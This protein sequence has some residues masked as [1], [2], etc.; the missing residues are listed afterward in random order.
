MLR[1]I[2]IEKLFGLYNYD[3][4][5][6]GHGETP[7]FLTGPNGYGKSTIL[8]IIDYIYREDFDSLREV[9]FEKLQLYF[10]N[11]GAEGPIR[12]RLTVVRL[13]RDRGTYLL[14]F[15]VTDWDTAIDERGTVFHYPGGMMMSLAFLMSEDALYYIHDQRLTRTERV[16]NQ[17]I[18]EPT[19]KGNAEEFSNWLSELSAK[20]QQELSMMNLQFSDSIS[21]DDYQSRMAAVESSFLPLYRY[22][23]IPQHDC[24]AYQKENSM[25]LHAYVCKMEQ[26]VANYAD[27]I[28]KIVAFDKIINSYEFSDKRFEINLQDG[29]RFVSDNIEHTPLDNTKLSSGER[30][31]LIQIYEL[32]FRAERDS[33]VL[34]DEP[35]IS[36]H[37]AWQLLYM[38]NMNQIAKLKNLQCLVATHSPIIFGSDYGLTLDLYEQNEADIENV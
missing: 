14:N 29:Y 28:D 3:I 20:I 1:R 8:N 7:L 18:T 19:I 38:E 9:S 36:I 15:Y 2:Q 4:E 35:E 21:E 31:I 5:L 22:G 11:S 16:L 33:L 17:E 26:V 6:R 32:L 23:I 24:L 10:E 27:D 25:F 34:V 12:K 37:Y 30:Q 13:S